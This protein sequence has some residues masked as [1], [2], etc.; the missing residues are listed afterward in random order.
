MWER[1]TRGRK[2]WKERRD[3]TYYEKWMINF[4]WMNKLVF[5]DVCSYRTTTHTQCQLE[6]VNC[7]IP[8]PVAVWLW[9]IIQMISSLLWILVSE[10]WNFLHIFS[11]CTN[12]ETA[13]SIDSE[14]FL[15][16]RAGAQC[17]NNWACIDVRMSP[18]WRSNWIYKWLPLVE[19]KGNEALKPS[20]ANN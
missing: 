11:S 12:D 13:I 6:P 7:I 19:T 20:K 2:T 10:Q 5:F 15:E 16:V 3:S 4:S 8:I 14:H 17:E 18:I 1:S 9:R